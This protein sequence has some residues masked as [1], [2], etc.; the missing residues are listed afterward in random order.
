MKNHIF[1]QQQHSK[2]QLDQQNYGNGIDVGGGGG[3]Q[4]QAEDELLRKNQVRVRTPFISL[5]VVRILEMFYATLYLK[6]MYADS[7]LL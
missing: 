4:Q 2:Q 1:T 7:L 3:A 6:D 5:C